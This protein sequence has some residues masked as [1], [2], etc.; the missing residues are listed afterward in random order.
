MTAKITV[1]LGTLTITKSVATGFD[2]GTRVVEAITKMVEAL[3][4]LGVSPHGATLGDVLILRLGG[5]LRGESEK[6]S[7][8][9]AAT[10]SDTIRKEVG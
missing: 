1:E 3:E 2:E 9:Y 7:S 8:P 6:I 5:R 10:T 4:A